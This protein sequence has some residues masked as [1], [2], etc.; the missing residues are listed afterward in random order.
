M[1]AR[2]LYVLLK[3]QAKIMVA[4]ACLLL[5]LKNQAQRTD[6]SLYNLDAVVIV[7]LYEPDL[8]PSK[9]VQVLDSL[10]MAR[11]ATRSVS[12]LL[13]E[14]STVYIKSYGSGGIAT[15]SFRGGNANHTALLWNGLNV[16]NA[17]LGQTDLSIIPGLFF[18]KLSLEYGGGSAL[19]GSGAI[20]GSI[21][22]DNELLFGKGLQAKLQAGFGS[23]GTRKTAAVAQLSTKRVASCTRLYYTVS[24]NNYTYKDSS[25]HEQSNK[26]MD[27]A[28]YTMM[29]LMQELAF[30]ISHKQTLNFRAWYN[31]ANRNLPSYTNSISKQN[32]LDETLKLNADW[33]LRQGR[34]RSTFRLA[35][36]QDKLNYNDS[37]SAIY[38]KSTI[39]TVIAESENVYRVGRHAFS[40]GANFTRYQSAMP[41][42][43]YRSGVRNDSIIRHY[44]QKFAVFALYRLSM[45]GSRLLY[46]V[47]VRKEWTNQTA[48]PFTGNTGLRFQ[49]LRWLGL[50]VTGGKAYRQPTLNDL[51]WPQGG[52]PQLKPEES[53]DVNGSVVLKTS[54]THFTYCFEGSYFNRH[55]QN[56]I[57]W[58][59]TASAYFSPRN[60][61]SV[62][63][64]GT[65]SRTEISYR[66]RDLFLKLGL[67]TAYVLST[68]ETAT[69][70][71]DDAVG[72]QLIYTPRY[73][74]Q[75]TLSCT[76][77]QV[78]IL[79]SQ[80]YTGYRFTSTDNTSWLDPYYLAN[81]KISYRHQFL[82]A[83]AEV[84]AAIY[85]IFDKP[86]MAVAN[87]PMPMRT[88]EAGFTI[89]YQKLL[90]QTKP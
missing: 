17:M 39:Q 74:G 70:E 31:K 8:Q 72:R 12:E 46:D 33:N 3:R 76:Y 89:C 9:K 6:T 71:N 42:D 10:V 24:E 7:P 61:A 18:D 53:Y 29:G 27:H 1:S 2:Q 88:Y 66:H 23:F 21:R 49:V 38:S 40:V 79:L 59:P 68:N 34:L 44:Q 57:I 75:A 43:V 54:T 5:P 65:E 26:R 14:Q 80:S 50:S 67:S 28:N 85:N 36:F 69:N 11:S 77:K 45:L 58:L 15:T 55:T 86:Y 25:N 13:A 60:I 73:A 81:V 30:Q 56:W 47:A 84:F 62:Y 90:K 37:L 87:R 64:R 41:V 48:I 63:S 52:N 20:G 4:A 83:S 35:G 22:L 19:W 16:Q 51:Y 32:Q 78:V 82:S